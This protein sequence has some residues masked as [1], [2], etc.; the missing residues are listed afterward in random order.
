LLSIP[1]LKTNA[2]I[3]PHAPHPARCI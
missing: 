2:A 1:L 3:R